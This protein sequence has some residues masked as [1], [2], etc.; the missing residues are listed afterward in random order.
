MNA[1]CFVFSVQLAK[2]MEKDSRQ[3]KGTEMLQDRSTDVARKSRWKI[4]PSVHGVGLPATVGADDC[5]SLKAPHH[6]S[7]IRLPSLCLRWHLYSH[8]Q[9]KRLGF[10]H[11]RQ[12]FRLELLKC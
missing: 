1:L 2:C 6:E 11:A 8:V 5:G 7:R 12:T 9:R 4:Q 10:C 3:H